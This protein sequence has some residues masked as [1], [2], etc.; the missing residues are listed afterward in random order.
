METTE[1][2]VYD[3]TTQAYVV[4][5]SGWYYTEA[6]GYFYFDSEGKKV[7]AGEGEITAGGVQQGEDSQGVGG[8][9]REENQG[10]GTE[11]VE[12]LSGSGSHAEVATVE[13]DKTSSSADSSD[14][15]EGE[16]EDDGVVEPPTYP[17]S[18]TATDEATVTT[19]QIESRYF[20]D[21]ENNLLYD[22]SLGQYLY[23]DEVSQGWLPYTT[24]AAASS[25]YHQEPTSDATMKLV[26]LS[27]EVLPVGSLVLV[28]GAGVTVGRD[29]AVERRIRLNEMPVSR[30]HATIYVD[31]VPLVP[32][33]GS[34]SSSSE[35][36]VDE[37]QG[38]EEDGERGE[39]EEG[40]V[41]VVQHGMGT[42]V[43]DCFFIVDQGST[44]GTFVNGE[45]LSEAKISSHPHRLSHND[46]ITIGTTTFEV[47]HHKSWGCEKC[48]VTS[49]NTI[50]TDAKPEGELATGGGG[51][52]TVGIDSKVA[53][54]TE[55]RQELKRL[56]RKYLGGGGGVGGNGA[57]KSRGVGKSSDGEGRTAS[58]SSMVTTDANP[59]ISSPASSLQYVDRAAIRRQLHQDDQATVDQFRREV[60]LN[61]A[62]V[63]ADSA[64]TTS[65]IHSPHPPK[66][67][68]TVDPKPKFI[69]SSN[70]GNRLLRKMG[71]TEG[72][73]LGKRMDGTVEPIGVEMRSGRQGLGSTSAGGSTVTTG[74]GATQS[75]KTYPGETLQQATRRIARERFVDMFDDG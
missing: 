45:R 39:D 55:R 40:K 51:N 68:K 24:D 15:E 50:S 2:W 58:A 74:A 21:Q 75:G 36:S 52:N 28:D 69:P 13:N 44:H 5:E 22:S 27:S 46:T 34:S 61:H 66:K 3:P 16:I 12:D 38:F 70:V 47:H 1:G 53:L 48:R 56:K 26:V 25:S 72:E 30:F 4:G 20:F 42:F 17:A 64:S 43:E 60:M 18:V 33:A 9:P 7:L 23:W 59:Y 14:W 71:W 35:A 63:Q 6:D 11:K 10:R 37:D 8:K 65:T 29:R 73:G 62:R 41:D 57:N 67:P 49:E 54:E 31:R 32:E 19:D